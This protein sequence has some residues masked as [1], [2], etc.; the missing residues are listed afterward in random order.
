MP[1]ETLDC[2]RVLRLPEQVRCDGMPRITMLTVLREQSTAS[3]AR[4][5]AGRPKELDPE[6]RIEPG[7]LWSS[8]PRGRLASQM[9]SSTSWGS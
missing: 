9:S 2:L 4:A 8:P 5:R 1:K 6:R 3:L 7:L